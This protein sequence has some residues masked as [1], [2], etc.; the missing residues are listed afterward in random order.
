MKCEISDWGCVYHACM[1]NE[2]QW[3]HM[4]AYGDHDYGPGKCE[5]QSVETNNNNNGKAVG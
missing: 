5:E 3:L 2:C 4:N 1:S